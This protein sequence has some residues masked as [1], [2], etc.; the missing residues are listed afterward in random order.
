M[1]ESLRSRVILSVN[2]ALLGEVFRELVAVS[3]ELESEKSF[4]LTFF[5]DSDLPGFMEEEISCIET[6]V[7]ADFPSSFEIS[8][9][10]RISRQP[11][12]T[13]SEEF[14]IFLRKDV[15]VEPI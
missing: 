9:E 7:I 5:V 3:C 8:H 1:N 11:R 12:L 10:V 14:W 4:K 15:G 2:R 13:P 6:E